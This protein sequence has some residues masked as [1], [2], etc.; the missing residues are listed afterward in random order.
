[1]QWKVD[2]LPFQYKPLLCTMY[3]IHACTL[4]TS[5]FRG[6]LAGTL[7]GVSSAVLVGALNIIMH[8]CFPTYTGGRAAPCGLKDVCPDCRYL[9]LFFQ[10]M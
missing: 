1:M 2:P 4:P 7:I 6:M 3:Q 10:P 9:K 5:F 8:N